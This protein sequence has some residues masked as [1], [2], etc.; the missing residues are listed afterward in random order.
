MST[1][2]YRKAIRDRWSGLA[3]LAVIVAAMGY[4]LYPVNTIPKIAV[5]A[6]L[7][8]GAGAITFMSLRKQM[9][10]CVC[11]SCEAEL[12]LVIEAAQAQGKSV[13]HCPFCG[14]KVASD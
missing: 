3:I 1:S 5:L 11:S 13:R 8:V 10:S 2:T 14:S 7:L 4:M 6:L 12:F 9:K